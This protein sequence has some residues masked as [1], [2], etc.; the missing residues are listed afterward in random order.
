MQ[1]NSVRVVVEPSTCDYAAFVG[2]ACEF[3]AVLFKGA[4]MSESVWSWATGRTAPVFTCVCCLA[5]TYSDSAKGATVTIV[6][7]LG[8]QPENRFIS[9]V[10]ISWKL[11]LK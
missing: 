1:L 5:L 7:K 4:F 9:S 10:V 6:N 11:L 3:K 2:F 8:I